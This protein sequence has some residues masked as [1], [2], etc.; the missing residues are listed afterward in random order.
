MNRRQILFALGTGVPL[1]ALSL[2]GGCAGA[3]APQVI[4]LT[5]AELAALIKRQFPLQKRLLEVVDVQLTAPNLH[6]LPER[7]RL[8]VD[9]SLTTQERLSG[10]SGRARLVFESALR[11]EP[12]DASVRLTQVQVQRLDIA[13]GGG[14]APA[15]PAASTPAG[16][17]GLTS[18]IAALLAERTMEDMT[19]YRVPAERQALLRQLGL[20][21]GAVTVT[22]RGLE[23][24]LARVGG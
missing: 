24:T 17:A 22:A 6:L 12:G 15:V 19:I 1:T 18:R 21:P 5:E 4:T 16:Q 9:L 7:N 2:L 10:K 23:I 8:A 13:A 20:Q 14:P 3:L 11:Y